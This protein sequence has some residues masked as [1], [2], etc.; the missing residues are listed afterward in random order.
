MPLSDD[1]KAM[2]RLLARDQSYEDIAALMGLGVDEVVAK[3]K[4]AVAQ[5]EQEGI[6][7]P[8]LPPAPAEAAVA[9]SPPEPAPEP[10]AATPPPSAPARPHLALPSGRG[11]Q[12]A[13]VAGLAALVVVV[14][15]L[16]LGGGDSGSGESTAAN[17]NANV[18]SSEGGGEATAAEQKPTLAR[19]TEVDGSG[20]SG[21][22]VFGRVKE[23]LALGIQ[24][25]GLQ[26]SSKGNAYTVWIAQSAKRML[27]LTTTEVPKSGRINAQYEIPTETLVYLANGTF[28]QIVITRTQNKPLE[29]ALEKATEAE[30]APTYTG[31]AVLRGTVTGPIVGAA[32]RREEREAEEGGE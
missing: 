14:L 5:L 6:P 2:L 12:A 15:L 27:P 28:D 1:Q 17:A 16:V 26:P 29:A 22:A 13:I 18:A 8:A 3:A 30:E 20:A 10:A 32:V 7:A 31:T 9:P 4:G 19:L 24:A 21:R 23:S 25:R 11:A